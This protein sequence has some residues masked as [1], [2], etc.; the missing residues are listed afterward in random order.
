MSEDD[1]IISYW[2]RQPNIQEEGKIVFSGI[3]PGGFN[4][5]D[6]MILAFDFSV[7]QEVPARLEVKDVKVLLNDGKGT[8]LATIS[9]GVDINIAIGNETVK[10]D[11]ESPL[12]MDDHTSPEEF[13]PVVSRDPD[14]FDGAWFVSFYAKDDNFGISHYEVLE[15]TKRI[16]FDDVGQG[17]LDWEKAQS[18]HLLKDQTLGSYIYVKAVDRAGNETIAWDKPQRDLAGS[19]GAGKAFWS[20]WLWVLFVLAIIAIILVNRIYKKR[21]ANYV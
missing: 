3:V 15:S 13:T 5:Q 6:G 14:I 1:S 11:G 7:K 4:G 20:K 2:V 9:T 18:P 21:K 8:E 16:N 12:I 19:S 10:T 17:A